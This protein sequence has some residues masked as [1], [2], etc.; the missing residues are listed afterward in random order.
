MDYVRLLEND[1]ELLRLS[2]LNAEPRTLIEHAAHNLMKARAGEAERQRRRR[3]EAERWE[4]HLDEVHR[5]AMAPPAPPAPPADPVATHGDLWAMTEAIA[6]ATKTEV[7]APLL[8]RIKELERNSHHDGDP[9][10]SRVKYS[11]GQVVKYAGY[12]WRCICAGSGLAP[13]R[14]PQHWEPYGAAPPADTT[15]ADPDLAA[16]EQRLAAV[17]GKLPGAAAPSPELA[18]LHVPFGKDRR[19]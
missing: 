5:R 10:N 4:R 14:R 11:P 8:E 9:W 15:L 13:D 18:A 17:E 3:E 19:R 7:V 12:S 1:P 16:L 6:V 2:L